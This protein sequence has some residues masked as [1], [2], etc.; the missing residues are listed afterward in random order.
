MKKNPEHQPQ[1]PRIC[2][3]VRGLCL[4]DISS[5]ILNPV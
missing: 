5:E 3:A 4:K 2:E 1:S